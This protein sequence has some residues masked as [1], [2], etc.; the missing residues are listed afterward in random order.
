MADFELGVKP[1]VAQPVLLRATV[2]P[3][4][5]RHVPEFLLIT[6]DGRL[7]IR[8]THPLILVQPCCAINATVF[9]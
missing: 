3:N 4:V 1:T 5:G 2:D 6:D 8:D 9:Y 7:K